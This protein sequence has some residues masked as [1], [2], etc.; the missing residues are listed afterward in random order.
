MPH[1]GFEVLTPVVMDSSI[2]WGITPGSPL[3]VNERF[4]GIHRLHLH[5]QGISEA[6]NKRESRWQAQRCWTFATFCAR[7][8]C[9]SS[10]MI[11]M[12][13]FMLES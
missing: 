3:K 10:Q 6:A 13:V 9:F 8:F 4:G 11:L 1:V 2:F 7:S 5:S 12:S